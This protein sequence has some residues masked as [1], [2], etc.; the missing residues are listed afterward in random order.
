MIALWIIL[1]IILYVTVGSVV[2][3]IAKRLDYDTDEADI[4]SICFLWPIFI[5]FALIVLMA[6]WII[7]KIEDL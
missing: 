5:P 6:R 1:G 7:N 2:A 4:F 3:G